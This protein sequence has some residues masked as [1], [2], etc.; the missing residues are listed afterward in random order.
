MKEPLHIVWIVMDATRAKSCSFSNPGL[1]LETTPRLEELAREAVVY[2]QAVSS[3][4]WTMA[5]HASM[6]TGTYPSRHGLVFDGDRLSDQFLTVAEV[7]QKEGYRT[8]AYS[9]NPYVSPFSGLHRGFSHFVDDIMDAVPVRAYRWLKQRR[10]KSDAGFSSDGQIRHVEAV[11]YSGYGPWMKRAIWEATRFFDKGASRV[12][13]EAGTEVE[14]AHRAGDSAFVF[15][16]FG[17]T[18]APYLPMGYFRDRFMPAGMGLKPWLVNQNA[19]RHFLGQCRM[20]PEDFELLTALYHAS[21]AY[22]DDQIGRLVTFLRRRGLLDRSLLIVTSDHGEN[23]GDHGMMGHQWSLADTLIHVPLLVRYPGGGSGGTRVVGQVQTMD[24]AP[25]LLSVISGQRT[26]DELARLREE[27]FDADV[28]ELPREANAPATH[29]VAF[30]ELLKPFGPDADRLRTSLKKYDR[31][32]LTARTP[33]WKWQWAS[34]GGESL[35]RLGTGEDEE[36]DLIDQQVET[37]AGLRNAAADRLAAVQAF[38]A[39]QKARLSGDSS[40]D[41]EEEVKERLR[42]LGYIDG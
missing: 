3:A 20:P 36:R 22:L 8:T 16:H 34:D 9:D 19:Y 15:M 38:I 40:L 4:C 13:R 24:L 18:H 30:S 2:E 31:Q 10:R 11:D 17:E 21:I 28:R 12:V 29:P 32:L 23:V 7:L 37:A 25:T 42:A 33:E 41:V 27:Q 6:F 35:F 26:Q 5:S 1:G 14:L 39:E